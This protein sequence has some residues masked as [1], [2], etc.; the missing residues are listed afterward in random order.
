MERK[1]IRNKIIKA[2]V[3]EKERELIKK[4]AKKYGY[5]NISKYLLAAVLFENITVVETTGQDIIYKSYSDYTKEIK[6]LRKELV[7][8]R[9]H[10]GMLK[11]ED[12]RLL[13]KVIFNMLDN[14]KSMLQIINEKLD[15]N[16]Y[17]K[18]NR[19]DI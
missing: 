1:E 10:A 19:G 16:I 11:P 18:V 5:K 3:T 12:S 7:E 6:K 2:R 17:K 14:Q 15:I 4:K 8:I 9:K 13:Q